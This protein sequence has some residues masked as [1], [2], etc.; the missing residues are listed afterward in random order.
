MEAFHHAVEADDI[1]RAAR[2]IEGRGLPLYLRGGAEPILAWLKSLPV[3]ILEARP[4]LLVAYATTLLF[5][6]QIGG[7]ELLVLAAESA[8]QD[9]EPDHQTRDLVGRI[10]S[11][12]ATVATA[13]QQADTIMIQAKRALE[14]L[15]PENFRFRIATTWELGFAYH[16]FGDRVAAR[17]AYA[18][19]L[20]KSDAIGHIIIRVM[21]ALGLGHV[22][23][24]RNSSRRCYRDLSA[25]YS[26][27]R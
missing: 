14:Y 20:T 21:S 4:V 27:R 16:L 25:C 5:M 10:A 6:G 7:V 17:H 9:V 24:F 22:E 2:L 26:V 18:D 15:A 23:E 1:D 13:L 19:A 3:S 12:R 8:L 11:I